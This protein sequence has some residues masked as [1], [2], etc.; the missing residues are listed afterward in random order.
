[1]A[2]SCDSGGNFSRTRGGCTG[3]GLCGRRLEVQCFGMG[4]AGLLCAGGCGPGRPP[5]PADRYCGGGRCYVLQAG[6]TECAYPEQCASGSCVDGVCCRQT[7]CGTCETCRSP[8]GTCVRL[9]PGI[10]PNSCTDGRA[11]RPD[12]TCS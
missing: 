3:T 5:C 8:G 6:G 7:A 2:P 10:D 11:C 1:M 9:P 4:C 12:G